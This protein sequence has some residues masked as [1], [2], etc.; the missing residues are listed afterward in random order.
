MSKLIIWTHM[1]QDLSYHTVIYDIM[2]FYY[3]H[4]N[5]INTTFIVAAPPK[6]RSGS[7]S[8][9]DRC[10]ARSFLIILNRRHSNQFYDL[11]KRSSQPKYLL[12]LIFFKWNILLP[13]RWFC[14][15]SFIVRNF[16][17]LSFASMN[18]IQVLALLRKVKQKCSHVQGK[19]S[20][21]KKQ[22]LKTS[23]CER[24]V[25]KWSLRSFIVIP[26]PMGL[27]FIKSFFPE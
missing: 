7:T 19:G 25:F 23:I 8:A 26:S 11:W 22:S 17:W 27:F 3:Y 24:I 21:Q 5:H 9:P 1:S 16:C 2:N 20:R 12:K 13:K 18:L 15:F 4:L 10:P 6:V 14:V